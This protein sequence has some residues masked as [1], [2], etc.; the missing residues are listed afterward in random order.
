MVLI[1]RNVFGN[2]Q[3][4]ANVE[5]KKNPLINLNLKND[6]SRVFYSIEQLENNL[7]KVQDLNNQS[8]R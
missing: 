3:P 2:P 7:I 4:L 5:K 6:Q 1:H 8:K